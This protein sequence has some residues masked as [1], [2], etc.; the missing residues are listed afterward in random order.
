MIIGSTNSFGAGGADVFLAKFDSEG[1]FSWAKT[2]GGT[3]FDYAWN[4]TN[5]LSD[6]G[7]IMV[8]YSGSFGAGGAD[9]FLVK[10]D[11]QGDTCSITQS[12]SPV[13]TPLS[14]T[15]TSPSLTIT[16]P[17]PSIVIPSFTITSPLPSETTVCEE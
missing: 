9:F 4:G 14:P 13:I 3:S 7:F 6:G 15:V 5:E 11:P 10:F 12:I 8:G 17:S 2:A 1:N 16:S